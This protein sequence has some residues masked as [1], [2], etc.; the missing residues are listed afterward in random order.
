MVLKVSG[1]VTI[2]LQLTET[3][4]SER[5]FGLGKRQEFGFRLTKLEAFWIRTMMLWMRVPG[6]CEI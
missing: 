3:E 1:C 2:L 4:K 6:P 5:G